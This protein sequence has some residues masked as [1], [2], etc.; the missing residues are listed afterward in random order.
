MSIAELKSVLEQV[1]PKFETPYII[2]HVRTEGSG[3]QISVFA[4][5]KFTLKPEPF[6]GE[7]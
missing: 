5:M 6:P 3:V 7:N 4:G 1:R 2:S